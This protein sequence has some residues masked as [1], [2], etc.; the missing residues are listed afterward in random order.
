MDM[1]NIEKI[2]EKYELSDEQKTEIVDA[3]KEN[4]KPVAD[5]Q[6]QKDK[7]DSLTA[8]LEEAKKSLKDFEGV[9]VGELQKRIDELNQQIEK[10]ETDYQAKIADRDFNDLLKGAIAEAKG[11]NV[12]A[13][14]ALLDVDA[15]KSSQNQK[16]DIAK[17]IK[18]LTEAEDSK[19]LFGEAEVPPVGKGSPIGAIRGSVRK[20]DNYLDEMYKDNPYYHPAT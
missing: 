15:L 13:I 3:V 1:Q 6:K 18:S 5:W 12:K 2:L 16:E 8:S 9:D 20:P 17:A 10:N 7:V 14:T 11:K 19:M 4:Y